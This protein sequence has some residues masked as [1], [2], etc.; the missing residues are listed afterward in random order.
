MITKQQIEQ[1]QQLGYTTFDRFVSER[2]VT[3]LRSIF[4]HEFGS[5][6]AMSVDVDHIDKAVIQGIDPEKMVEMIKASGK[7]LEDQIKGRV[8]MRHLPYFN[9]TKELP[10]IFDTEVREKSIEAAEALLGITAEELTVFAVLLWKPPGSG[11]TTWHQ[12]DSFDPPEAIQCTVGCWIALA[13][14]NEANG[15][16]TVIPGSHVGQLRPH[17]LLGRAVVEPAELARSVS[18][19]LP[20]GGAL[21]FNGRLLHGSHPNNSNVDRRNISILLRS[22]HLRTAENHVPH[23]RTATPRGSYVPTAALQ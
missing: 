18:V 3:K 1:Y 15:C 12:E 21:L 11:P 23:G 5:R 17:P 9:P 19:P 20:A 6:S 22:P 16:M 2:D 7:Y 4:D 8:A 10:A 14:A 13:E